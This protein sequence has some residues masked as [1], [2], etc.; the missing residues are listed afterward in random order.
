M[1]SVTGVKLKRTRPERNGRKFLDELAADLFIRLK[2]RARA[3]HG[4][5]DYDP[6][7]ALADIAL[8]RTTPQELAAKCHTHLA[9]FFYAERA[10]V[11]VHHHRDEPGDAVAP[12]V[13]ADAILK[14]MED[15]ARE[16]TAE[17]LRER[18]EPP[19]RI[20]H[21]ANGHAD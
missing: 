14:R 21:G 8:D 7:I 12:E 10:V 4:V 13:V 15:A 18:E 17:H 1:T 5:E 2:E 19:R 16:R 20:T 3:V 9:K 6:L 11:D